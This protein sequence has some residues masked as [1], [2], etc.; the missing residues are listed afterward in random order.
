MRRYTKQKKE[1]KSG[2][3]CIQ[4]FFHHPLGHCSPDRP[5]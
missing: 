5:L 4:D 2:K 1:K 3:V